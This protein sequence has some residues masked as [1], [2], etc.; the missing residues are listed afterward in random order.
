LSSRGTPA[1]P[2]VGILGGTFD[3]I[4]IGHLRPALEVYEHL[5]LDEVR[6]VPCHVPPHRRRPRASAE[7]RL[8]MVELAIEGEPGLRVDD[9]ELRRPGPSYTIDTLEGLRA[10]LGDETGLCLIMGMDAFAGLPSWH[11]WRELTELAHIAVSHRPA[12]PASLDLDLGDWLDS[13]RTE[14]PAELREA[15]CGRVIF[16]AVTQLDISATTIRR[17]VEAGLSP[18][19]L[20]PD[21]V[22]AYI[23]AEGLYREPV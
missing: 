12:S 14:D 11:R 4:H 6:L 22:A 2:L 23:T 8:R 13:V 21:P 9:R 19:Y 17:R 7:Q 1:R 18:R 3:P 20:T 15:P 5:G 16:V 10:E